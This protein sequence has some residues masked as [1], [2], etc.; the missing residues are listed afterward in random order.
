VTDKNVLLR[1]IY[2]E[3]KMVHCLHDKIRNYSL[4]SAFGS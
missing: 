1:L 3:S 2:V 4:A